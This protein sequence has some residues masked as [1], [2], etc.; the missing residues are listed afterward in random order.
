MLN[1]FD[2]DVGLSFPAY[3]FYARII[4]KS[5]PSVRT[6]KSSKLFGGF[7]LNLVLR[8]TLKYLSGEFLHIENLLPT[9]LT[10]RINIMLHKLIVFG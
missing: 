2:A 9:D 1:N 6:C 4:G 7:I 10:N 8:S 3:A 5:C